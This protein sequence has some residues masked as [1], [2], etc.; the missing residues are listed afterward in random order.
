MRIL[1]L[2]GYQTSGII[3]KNQSKYMTKIL[4]YNFIFPNAPNISLSNDV[5]EI[6]TKFYKKPYYEWYKYDYNNNIYHGLDESINLIKTLGK[7]DGVVGFSQGACMAPN[8]LDIVDAKFFISISGINKYNCD[9]KYNIP[10]FHFI[11]NND[12]I[13]NKSLDFAK[14]FDKPHIFWYNGGHQIPFSSSKDDFI[15]CNEYI[16]KIVS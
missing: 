15:K 7:F 8:I 6:I 3:M 10:S 4:N 13:R 5:P 11:G 12:P 14:Q 16:Q 1:A 2:H 9:K